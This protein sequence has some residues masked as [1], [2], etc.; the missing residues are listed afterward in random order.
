MFPGQDG[1]REFKVTRDGDVLRVNDP[2]SKN[3]VAV[4]LDA[5]EGVFR[6]LIEEKRRMEFKRVSASIESV[7][8]ANRAFCVMKGSDSPLRDLRPH[9]PFLM[10]ALSKPPFSS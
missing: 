2:V 7:D 5:S 6:G 3:K 9:A 4:L 8:R 1:S 10:R